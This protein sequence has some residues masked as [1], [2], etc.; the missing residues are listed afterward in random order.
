MKVPNVSK[1]SE[2]LKAK[3][4]MIDR[5]ILSGLVNNDPIP[6]AEKAAP[7]VVCNDAKVLL[8]EFAAL[9]CKLVTPIGIPMMVVS[10]IPIRIAPGTFLTF[11]ITM[12]IKPIRASK[13]PAW[14]KLTSAGTMPPLETTDS[15]P[16]LSVSAPAFNGWPLMVLMLEASE[17]NCKKPAFLIPM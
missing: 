2:K 11:R 15:T 7:K 14:V 9:R 3:M 5:A 10:R 4:V 17:V 13:A 8:K 1:M 6:L 16:C 12:M